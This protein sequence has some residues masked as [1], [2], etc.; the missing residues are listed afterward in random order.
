MPRFI[1]FDPHHP[2]DQS[3]VLRL[4]GAWTLE[5]IQ[6]IDKELKT[7]SDE[8]KQ[9]AIKPEIEHLDTAGA[10]LLFELTKDKGDIPLAPEQQT[11]LQMIKDND[12]DFSDESRQAASRLTAFFSDVGKKSITA[13]HNIVDLVTFIGETSV[14]LANV[15]INPQKI[16][17]TSI[18][19]HIK[20][21]GIAAV[22]IISL[23][24][25][26]ISIVLAYQGANQ[27]RRFG[28]E[29]FTI[30]MVAVSVLRE[31]GVLLTAIMIAGRS[32]SAF[33]A[34]IGVM[35]VNEEVDAM[36]IIGVNPFEVLVLP[37]VLAL[38]ITLPILTFI[39][40]L[41]GL[42]GGGIISYSL[43]NIGSDQYLDRFRDAVGLNDFWVGMVKA[44]VFAFFIAVVGCM[45]GMQVSGSAESVGRLTTTAVVQSIF[46]VLLLDALF[47][48]LFTKMG[49]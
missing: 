42:V 14:T 12:Q 1:D 37:R 27:L 36:R 25:F 39:A 18:V 8:Q 6:E 23:I 46:V 22:P 10:A 35:K 31:M 49:V 17:F 16:R 48:I 4:M 45:R 20:E 3:G 40:D 7:L 5:N 32:G 33:T 13:W 47:S 9:A 11:L 2:T 30:N 28:A 15:V 19:R 41:M 44:P 34:E 38:I 24:A 29:I 26:L 21:T 43:M